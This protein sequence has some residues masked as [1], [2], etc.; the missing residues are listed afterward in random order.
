MDVSHDSPVCIQ[1][2]QKIEIIGPWNAKSETLRCEDWT[3]RPAARALRHK[4][5]V[6]FRKAH[7]IIS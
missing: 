2:R 4:S 6:S 7:C 5:G 1:R 3:H